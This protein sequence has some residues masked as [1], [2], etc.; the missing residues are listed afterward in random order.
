MCLVKTRYNRD[1]AKA[2]KTSK[3]R[4]GSTRA[5]SGAART[6]RARAKA[7]TLGRE[8]WLDTARRAL[9]EEG[10]AGVEI[11]KLAKRLGS[12]RGGFYWFFKDRAQ[13]LDE[14]LKEWA[15]TSTVLF[16]RVL[17]NHHQDGLEEYL[18]M[19]NLWVD[20][21]EYDPQWDGAV[22]DWARTSKTVRKVVEAVD[23]KRITV[24]EEI[25]RH[26]GYQGKEA[27]VRARVMYYHQV[28]YYAMGVRESQRERRALIP[29][30]K[31]A[32][33]GRD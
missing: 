29:F 6:T 15:D 14:L 16:E 13:L 28:G 27:N 25:F 10:I 18:A 30:Y 7:G 9:I 19:T 5:P 3:T 2:S 11:N 24:L 17:H 8:I 31:K 20:E 22:R 21:N 12:S 33:T 4:T 26:I 32:L 1:V 23:Q